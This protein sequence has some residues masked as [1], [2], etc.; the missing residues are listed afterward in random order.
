[1]TVPFINITGAPVEGVAT[2]DSMAQI[3]PAAGMPQLEI[4]DYSQGGNAAPVAP[5]PEVPVAPA[6]P[7]QY[8]SAPQAKPVDVAAL[9]APVGSI[10]T[11]SQSSTARVDLGKAGDDAAKAR[12]EAD[13]A[14]VGAIQAQTANAQARAAAQAEM[15]AAKAEQ[16]AAFDAQMALKAKQQADGALAQ[17]KSIQQASDDYDRAAS[18][19]NADRWWQNQSTGAK[20]GGLI[21]IALSGLGQVFSAKGGV[22]GTRNGALDMIQMQVDRDIDMQRTA[23]AAK[24]RGI[25]VKE[26]AYASAR[27][28]GADDMQATAAAKA[29]AWGKIEREFQAKIDALGSDEAKAAGEAA[30]AQVQQRRADELQRLAE[31]TATRSQTSSG[32]RPVSG[33]EVMQLQGQVQ[34]AQDEAQRQRLG[35][36]KKDPSLSTA[37]GQARDGESFRELAKA[38]LALDPAEKA[39]KVLERLGRKSVLGP[40]DEALFNA[41]RTDILAFAKGPMGANLGVL[42]GPDMEVLDPQIPTRKAWNLLSG[43]DTAVTKFMRSKIEEAKGSL[44]GYTVRTE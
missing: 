18:N 8:V 43:R 40:E 36:V 32:S 38:K 14:S 27:A 15:S 21:S 35:L 13:A 7:T 16:G 37:Y 34:G 44:K 20:I 6:G 4:P 39:I 5:T 42:A 25:R 10:S 9:L 19:L 28:A 24:E 26:S 41:A 30:L 3:T 22:H 11:G 23:L 2:P 1:M 31:V 33:L 29:A 17:A 12:S